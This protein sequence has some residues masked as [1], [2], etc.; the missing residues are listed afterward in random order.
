MFANNAAADEGGA[1]C[2][3]YKSHIAFEDNSSTVFVSNTANEG[4]S[5]YI[6]RWPHIF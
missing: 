1:I 5:T 6:Y 3:F 2:C 4:A